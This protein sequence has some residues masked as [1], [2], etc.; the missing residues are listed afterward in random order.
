[1][2]AAAVGAALGLGD[3]LVAVLR[4][5]D[6]T[7][8]QA[9]VPIGLGATVLAAIGALVGALIHLTAIAGDLAWRDDGLARRG[10]L[11]ASRRATL[12]CTAALVIVALSLC[13]I[14]FSVR[15]PFGLN[16][17]V[18]GVL[19]AAIATALF[20]VVHRFTTRRAVERLTWFVIA[21]TTLVIEYGVLYQ[22]SRLWPA[23]EP[24]TNSYALMSFGH[25]LG[26]VALIAVMTMAIAVTVPR[27]SRGVASLGWVGRVCVV[28]AGL[29]VMALC[30]PILEQRPHT[31][32]VVLYDRT[33]LVYRAIEYA[34][35]YTRTP[36]LAAGQ[37]APSIE[38]NDTDSTLWRTA[39]PR[40]VRGVILVIVDAMRSDVLGAHVG[41]RPVT[42]NLDAWAK[43][44]VRF[45]RA[46]CPRSST[47]HSMAAIFAGRADPDANVVAHKSLGPM[48]KWAGIQSAG[49]FGHA[50][51]ADTMGTLDRQVPFGDGPTN[52]HRQTAQITLGEV[53]RYLDSVKQRPFFLVAHF[54]DPHAH[55]LPN[56]AYDFGNNARG[57]YLGEVAYVD[58]HLGEL[59]RGLRE[60]GLDDEVALLVT[61]D[62]GEELG[63]HGYYWHRKRVYEESV[64]VP[65]QIRVPGLGSGEVATPVTL[66]DLAPTILDLFGLPIPAELE[67]LSLVR[68]LE[69]HSPPQRVL[70]VASGDGSAYGLV[71]G[72]QKLIFNTYSRALEY[73]DL[74]RDPRERHNLADVRSGDAA[75]LLIELVGTA[76]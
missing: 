30:R 51:L 55:Y 16:R 42:P 43:S 4:Y 40:R 24:A 50:V 68:A 66:L 23:W 54:Y 35:R 41:T 1:M 71:A 29:T 34:P 72:D 48:L 61:S 3:T 57:L 60:R 5:S 73:F 33:R 10:Q 62:H 18:A 12:A 59:V 67:G 2:I 53:N 63:D 15:P 38:D 8:L 58:Q 20:I 13:F 7:W 32:R 37:L 22:F 28:I 27:A 56:A 76:P 17:N 39:G 49:I 26:L 6:L 44:S 52:R 36:V 25:T 19:A 14:A 9:A 65:L 11:V 74:G 21:A 47:V 64:R 75:S 45:S 69:G 31:D 70:R 46:Y